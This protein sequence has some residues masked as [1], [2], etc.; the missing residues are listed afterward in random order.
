MGIGATDMTDTTQPEAL[1][2]AD[3]LAHGYPLALDAMSAAAELRRLYT[4]VTELEAH[5][6]KPAAIEHIACDVSKTGRESNMAQAPAVPAVAS[7]E[8]E[9]WVAAY[10]TL[11]VTRD[12][13][14]YTDMTTEMLWHAWQAAT[15]TKAPVGAFDGVIDANTRPGLAG[16]EYTCA[17]DFAVQPSSGI[18]LCQKCGLSE[19]AAR[20]AAP[21][22]EAAPAV[23]KDHDTAKLV[24]DL[25]DVAIEF[26]DS[27]QLRERIAQIVRPV[28]T[29]MAQAPAAPAQCT[30]SDSWNCKYCRKNKVCDALGNCGERPRA[31]AALIRG[32]GITKGEQHGKP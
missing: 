23:W 21:Q 2:L 29:L 3:E 30:N 8:F 12:Q 1:R 5:V 20:K 19:V 14:A 31:A 27:Q 6:Q 17:H 28:A 4:R 26:H 10:S 22:P 15:K 11:P 25:R 24:N 32:H 9:Q 18:K 16:V 7:Q 13:H